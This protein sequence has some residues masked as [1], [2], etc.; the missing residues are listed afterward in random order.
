MAPSQR[1]L[2]RKAVPPQDLLP[3]QGVDSAS[4]GKGRSAR[5]AM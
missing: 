1:I 2:S 3:T 4:Q 5:G